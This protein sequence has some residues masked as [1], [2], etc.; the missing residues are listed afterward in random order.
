MPTPTALHDVAI[1]GAGP[2]GLFS[3]FYA[4]MR[5]LSVVLVDSLPVP[6][7]QLTTLYPEKF[8]YDAPGFPCVLAKDLAAAL[9]QQAS[10]YKPLFVLGTQV[11][12]LETLPDDHFSITT[13]EGAVQARAVIIAAGVG[14]FQPRKLRVAGAA[15]F[16]N[17][18]GLHYFVQRVDDFRGKRVLIVGGG[19]SAVD[20]ANMLAP[21]ADVTLIHRRDA[22]RALEESVAKMRSS[23]V[24]ILTPYELRSL[25]GGTH[26][27]QA[28][29]YNNGTNGDETIDVDAVL[30]NIGFDGSLGP[31]HNWDLDLQNNAIVVDSFMRTSRAGVFACG[32]ICTYPGKLKLIATGFGEAA[33]AA[34]FVKQYLDPK[35]RAFPGHSSEMKR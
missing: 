20:W 33:I 11:K 7:G 32:D 34:N 10:Q 3:A 16:E 4:G 9:L 24:R 6:G 18:R 23:S 22:F 15:N 19:D 30:V 2:I 5:H 35:A 21:V 26:V 27:S 1:V 17:G 13:G 12:T 29:I 25:S 28:V 8:I 31:I 14:S